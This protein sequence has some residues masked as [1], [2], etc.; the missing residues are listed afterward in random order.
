MNFKLKITMVSFSL[1]DELLKRISSEPVQYDWKKNSAVINNIPDHNLEIIYALI[2]HHY[3][4][5]NKSADLKTKAPNNL[6]YG[7]RA[8]NGGKG[9]IYVVSNLPQSLQAVIAEYIKSVVN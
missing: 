1:Y 4:L 2:L 6:P 8:I 7:G 3:Y 5:A 9:I